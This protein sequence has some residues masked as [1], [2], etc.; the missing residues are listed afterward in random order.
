MRL[1]WLGTNAA[2]PVLHVAKAL[3]MEIDLLVYVRNSLKVAH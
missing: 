1:P 3:K 2:S